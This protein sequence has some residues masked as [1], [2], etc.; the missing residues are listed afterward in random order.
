MLARDNELVEGQSQIQKS[1]EEFVDVVL[2]R[3]NPDQAVL[4]APYWSERM[5]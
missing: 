5:V 4:F 3:I 2:D 1:A